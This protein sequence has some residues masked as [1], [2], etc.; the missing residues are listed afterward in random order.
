[1]AASNPDDSRETVPLYDRRG[2]RE[3]ILGCRGTQR[4][5]HLQIQQRSQPG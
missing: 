5:D 2:F 3:W 4:S 1:M